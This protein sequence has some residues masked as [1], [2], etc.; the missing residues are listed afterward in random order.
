MNNEMDNEMDREV[1]GNLTEIEEKKR[2]VMKK[3]KEG[4]ETWRRWCRF[5]EGKY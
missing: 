5:L 3:Y 1:N 2:E 4:F